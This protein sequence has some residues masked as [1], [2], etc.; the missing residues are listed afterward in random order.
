MHGS[1]AYRGA[2]R[3]AHVDFLLVY[4]IGLV[5]LVTT[6]V[7]SMEG[8]RGSEIGHW[9][10]TALN[11]EILDS[12]QFGGL[13]VLYCEFFAGRFQYGEQVELPS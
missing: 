10:R 1:R 4:A 12:V 13:G 11:V 5:L 7:T 6:I 2:V 9:F 8:G 3:L